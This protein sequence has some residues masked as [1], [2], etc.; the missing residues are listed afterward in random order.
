MLVT[1][2]A[3]LS[4]DIRRKRRRVE[5]QKEGDQLIMISP[6]T[7]PS[8]MLATDFNNAA[9]YKNQIIRIQLSSVLANFK[10]VVLFFYGCDFTAMA[11]ADLSLIDANY[12]R[13]EALGTLPLAMST[14]TEVVHQAFATRGS[15][16]GLE[17]PPNFPLRK[18]NA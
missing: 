14:D 8:M 12:Q 10:A 6:P 13:F 9:V 2:A 11:R 4:E 7:N 17:Q 15:P 16:D 5:D 3:D 18:E 1:T